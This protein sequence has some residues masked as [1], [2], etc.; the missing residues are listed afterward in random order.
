[1]THPSSDAPVV[2]LGAGIG[3]L[4]AALTLARA[5]YRV[6][7]FERTERLLEVGAGLQLSPNALRVL[8]GFGLLP[9]LKARSGEPA[10]VRIRSARNGRDLARVPLGPVARERYGLP[11]LV[12]HRADLQQVLVQAVRETAAIRLTLGA[13]LG[14]VQ[15]AGDGLDIQVI[16][17]EGDRQLRAAALIG[18]D[19]VRSHVRQQIMGGPKPSFSGR[20][21]YRATLPAD[22]VPDEL[23]TETGLWLGPRA[24]LVHYPVRAGREFNIVALVEEDWTSTGWSE[25]ADR[26]RLLARFA[27][28]PSD[29]RAVLSRPDGWLR[30]ALCA[31]DAGT[32]WVKGRIALLGD[33]CHAM[34]PF[35]AQ[36]AAMAI[37]DAA[38]L[39][40]V[41]QGARD[42]PAALARYQQLR[43]PRTAQVQQAAATNASIYHLGWPA[44]LARDAVLRA[45][46][47]ERLLK[48]MDWIYAW[49][50]SAPA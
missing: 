42:I 20:T 13:E 48:R 24:H 16:T 14:P 37:E 3:G 27:D 5:G 49:R 10:T 6:D 43:Q 7:L 36:G 38:V 4:T 50:D 47:P 45:S 33:A 34:L 41:L 15:E 12:L 17:P 35:A 31:V 44:C 46:S 32:P 19:G 40:R 26:D 28:W 21:A 39:G 8:D 11:Y 2:I 22:E 9:A 18:A 29:I 23:M 30:W 1:M 25:P